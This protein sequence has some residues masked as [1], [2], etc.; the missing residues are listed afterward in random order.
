MLKV[1]DIIEILEPVDRYNYPNKWIDTMDSY[2]GSKAKIN[3]IS[4]SHAEEPYYILDTNPYAWH[5]S[6][7]K[8][9]SR[10]ADLETVD[11][12]ETVML[13][14]GEYAGDI[15]TVQ[16]CYIINGQIYYNLTNRR[17]QIP[18]DHVK[19]IKQLTGLF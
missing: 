13:I 9:I 6:N 1:G 18:S 19:P 15:E 14:K 10:D 16:T 12:H 2:I 8:L 4:L 7:L 5:E 17:T 3:K 11:L